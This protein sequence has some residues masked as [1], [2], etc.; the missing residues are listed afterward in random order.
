MDTE[1]SEADFHRTLMFQ[2][3]YFSLVLKS[4]Q[5]NN[6]AMLPGSSNIIGHQNGI[7]GCFMALCLSPDIF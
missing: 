6:Y 2:C 1:T 3:L 4:F 7:G 5:I